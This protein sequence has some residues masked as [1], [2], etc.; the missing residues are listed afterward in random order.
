M[1]K[2]LNLTLYIKRLLWKDRLTNLRSKQPSL[3]LRGGRHLYIGFSTYNPK[4]P[5]GSAT[6]FLPCLVYYQNTRVLP[7][8]QSCLFRVISHTLECSHGSPYW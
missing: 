6:L 3:W 2:T 8:C 7:G 5:H 4:L 1:I